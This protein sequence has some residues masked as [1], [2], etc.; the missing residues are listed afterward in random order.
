M[1]YTRS[2][3]AELKE[4]EQGEITFL[5]L[6][7]FER[8]VKILRHAVLPEDKCSMKQSKKQAISCIAKNKWQSAGECPA[9]SRLLSSGKPD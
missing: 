5:F 3:T 8:R 6:K 4:T 7:I 1:P 9:I 2:L